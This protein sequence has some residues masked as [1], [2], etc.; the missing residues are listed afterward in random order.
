MFWTL[1]KSSQIVTD[2]FRKPTDRNQYLLTSSCHPAHVTDNIPYSLALRIVRICSETHD[3]DKRLDELK[4]LLLSRNYR[5][6]MINAAIEKAKSVSRIQ[7]L[8]RVEKSEVARRPVFVVH[9]DPRLPSVTKIVKKHWRTMIS[10]D[11]HLREVYPLPPL[12]AY[13]RPP[14]IKDKIVRAKVPPLAPRRPTRIK[15]GMKK[16][17]NCSICP[18][19]DACS[20]VKSTSN[21]F[22]SDINT[23]VNCKSK[24]IIYCITCIKCRM[25]YVGESERSLQDRFSEHLGYVKN[26]HLTKAT[27]G[28]YNLP[29]HTVSDMRVTIVEKIHSSD[30]LIRKQR[31]ELFIQKL[32]T[33][34]KG[35]NKK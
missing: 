2:L 3:R 11:P 13:R 19:I 6:G 30:P 27:G 31:E 26:K 28:H 10:T 14:N 4:I 8:T 17:N 25:Q 12:V 35:L 18:F 21:N 29:G 24:N 16:C 32:N 9:Y 15:P 7:A 34:Y 1:L 22:T 5:L 23:S 33:K 20:N